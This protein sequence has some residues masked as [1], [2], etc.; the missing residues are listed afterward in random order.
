MEVQDG[1][2]E[3]CEQLVTEREGVGGFRK[4]KDTDAAFSEKEDRAGKDEE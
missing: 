2:G 1:G 3:G 4:I